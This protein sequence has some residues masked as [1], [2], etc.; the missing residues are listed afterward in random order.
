MTNTIKKKNWNEL[1]NF[2]RNCHNWRQF[3]W[4]LNCFKPIK[5]SQHHD[6]DIAK[7]SIYCEQRSVKYRKIAEKYYREKSFTSRGTNRE[8]SFLYLLRHL[9]KMMTVTVHSWGE[10]V[11]IY[12]TQSR[13]HQNV[14]PI[15][16]TFLKDIRMTKGFQCP[17]DNI[18]IPV[19]SRH[20]GT[21]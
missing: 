12:Y 15:R 20:W 13:E 4:K 8:W 2:I 5:F 18:I 10:T 3:F 1:R 7:H 16:K 21:C 11:T 19:S 6:D 17:W 14:S 9:T